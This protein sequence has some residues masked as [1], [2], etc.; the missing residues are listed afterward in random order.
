M[1]VNGLLFNHPR[2]TTYPSNQLNRYGQRILGAN[3]G[4]H[5]EF[6]LGMSLT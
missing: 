5:D 1:W 4:G 3:S 2:H 6:F